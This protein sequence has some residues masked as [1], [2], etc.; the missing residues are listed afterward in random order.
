MMFIPTKGSLAKQR[1]CEGFQSRF[2]QGMGR[3]NE[4]ENNVC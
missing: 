3:F 4:R 1:A 2:N